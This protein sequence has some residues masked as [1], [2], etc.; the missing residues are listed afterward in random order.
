MRAWRSG[1]DWESLRVSSCYVHTE[2][3]HHDARC[4]AL[5]AAKSRA[6][7]QPDSE[8]TGE[9]GHCDVGRGVER[10]GNRAQDEKLGD[11]MTSVHGNKLGNEGKEE[12]RRFRIQHLSEDTL[13]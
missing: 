12:Q 1:G 2:P 8:R 3:N 9:A 7:L 6:L 10:D 13:H 11:D 4:G 5:A